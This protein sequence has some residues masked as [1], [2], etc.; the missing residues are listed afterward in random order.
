MDI[1][2]GCVKSN[3]ESIRKK[4]QTDNRREGLLS[5]RE[6]PRSEVKVINNIAKQEEVY[7][8]D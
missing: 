3:Y 8:L 5:K 1:S 6:Q 7:M 2:I 4:R